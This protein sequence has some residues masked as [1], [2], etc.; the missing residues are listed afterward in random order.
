MLLIQ[1]K[2]LEGNGIPYK[3]AKN[4]SFQGHSFVRGVT[5]SKRLRQTAADLYQDDSDAGNACLIVDEETHFTFWHQIQEADLTAEIL[6]ESPNQSPVQDFMQRF[7]ANKR[8]TLP[9]PRLTTKATGLQKQ[10]ASFIQSTLASTTTPGPNNGLNRT[11]PQRLAKSDPTFF[12][13]APQSSLTPASPTPLAAKSGPNSLQ[14]T[15]SL[16]PDPFSS[17]Y[18]GPLFM[19]S[20]AAY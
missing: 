14:D 5:F 20:P 18:L 10:S 11:P 7:V 2:D 17:P 6:A 19:S 15:P 8:S 13:I 16:S 12:K 3:N 9:Q 1:A 4:I